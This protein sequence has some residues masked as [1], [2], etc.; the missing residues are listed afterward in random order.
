MHKNDVESLWSCND[1]SEHC[2]NC[3]VAENDNVKHCCSNSTEDED[4]DE[5]EKEAIRDDLMSMKGEV[6]LLHQQNRELLNKLNSAVILLFVRMCLH[7]K[8]FSF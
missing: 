6:K 4:T 2:S 3:I 5:Y 7:I 8:F 1:E